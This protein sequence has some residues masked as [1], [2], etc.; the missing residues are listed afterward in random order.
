MLLGVAELVEGGGEL[1]WS[2]LEAGCVDRAFWIIA[3][4]IFG[5]RAAK[6]SV[7]GAG[8]RTPD[9]AFLFH[10]EKIMRMG[11]DWIFEGNFIKKKSR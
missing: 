7:E 1:A 4:K 9:Q 6:T 11:S 3:P 10:P 5:G 2:F 8:V